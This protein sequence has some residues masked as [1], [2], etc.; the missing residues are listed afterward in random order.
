MS[1]SVSRLCKGGTFYVYARYTVINERDLFP[2][3][4]DIVN[5][6]VEDR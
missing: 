6:V 3:I 1:L 4:R 2:D 5:S